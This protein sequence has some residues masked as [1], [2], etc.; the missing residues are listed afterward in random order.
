MFK[1][2]VIKYEET[3]RDPILNSKE[4][5]I[6]FLKT[7]FIALLL[8]TTIRDFRNVITKVLFKFG[9]KFPEEF[10]K[11]TSNVMKKQDPYIIER[12]IAILYGLAMYFF[13]QSNSEAYKDLIVN[14]A[15]NLNDWFFQ[16]DSKFSTTHFFIRQHA[17]FVI[18]LGLLFDN[19]IFSKES[20]ILI[21]PPYK[22]GGIRIWGELSLE[23]IGPFKSGA[24]PFRL[25]N[26]GKY[27]I[28]DLVPYD[29]RGLRDGNEYNKLLKN[30]YWRMRDLGFSGEIFSDIDKTISNLNVRI[31][32]ED[33]V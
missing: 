11:L 13:N 31:L 17:R 10:F 20:I 23:D 24:Y 26:F 29:N 25:E 32:Y 6:L 5:E 21:R 30:I 1:E 14:W 3:F 16:E 28:G 2:I 33:G 19:Q 7:F 22:T 8:P 12:I 27:I 4:S 9:I 15:K 18:E